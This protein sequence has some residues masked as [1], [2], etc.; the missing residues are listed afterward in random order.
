MELIEQYPAMESPT[1]SRGGGADLYQTPRAEPSRGIH[2]PIGGWLAAARSAPHYLKITVD[3]S[4]A[5]G[6]TVFVDGSP[7]DTFA[8]RGR[9]ADPK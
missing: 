5:C 8:I 3:G 9:C 4:N 1:S 7:S 2:F 6:E